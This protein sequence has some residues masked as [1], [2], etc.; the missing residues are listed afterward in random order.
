[1]IRPRAGRQAR[2]DPRS[3]DHGPQLARSHRA[4]FCTSRLVGPPP[5]ASRQESLEPRATGS[6]RMRSPGRS[7]EPVRWPAGF[8]FE[9]GLPSLLRSSEP[10]LTTAASRPQA[11]MQG[12]EPDQPV[13]WFMGRAAC[14]PGR[15]AMKA[16]LLQLEQGFAV[17]EFRAGP[18]GA[19]RHSGGRAHRRRSRWPGLA[20][21][22]GC[23]SRRAG[24]CRTR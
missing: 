12:R 22:C 19:P 9:R 13:G 11:V 16:C 5:A 6:A 3:R 1:V 14:H 8:G 17:R 10:R 2:D 21:R 7:A 4:L 23:G 20:T 24:Y 15:P 18:S